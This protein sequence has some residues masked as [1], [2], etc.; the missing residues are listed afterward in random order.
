M[1]ANR[2]REG[3]SGSQAIRSVL[4]ALAVIG[5]LLFGYSQGWVG[6]GGGGIDP[7]P[8]QTVEA[9][10]TRVVDGD[11]VVVEID[12]VEERL[13]YIGIDTPET[14]A[15]GRP[16]ECF[17]PQASEFNARMVEGRSVELVIGAEPRDRYDRLLGYVWLGDLFVNA[18]LVRAGYATA[19]TIPPNDRYAGAFERLES[20]A[21]SAGLGK[22]SACR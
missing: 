3:A 1:A 21:H 15:P 13:R 12:G 7:Q 10:V 8:G 5:V 11:T 4:L 16:V 18:E 6:G 2:R 20:R 14:V 22:W 19:L 17:G 9:E